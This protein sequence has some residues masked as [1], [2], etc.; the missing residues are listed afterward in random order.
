MHA[1]HRPTARLNQLLFH[2]SGLATGPATRSSRADSVKVEC[3][4]VLTL[5]LALRH[6]AGEPFSGEPGSRSRSC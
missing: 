4:T 6:L 1:R 2:D 3:V 5:F